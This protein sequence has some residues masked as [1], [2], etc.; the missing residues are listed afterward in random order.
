MIAN[1]LVH[2]SQTESRHVYLNLKQVAI[3]MQKSVNISCCD[4]KKESREGYVSGAHALFD[5]APNSNIKR[6]LL[7]FDPEFHAIWSVKISARRS[8]PSK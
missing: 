4:F 5:I 7:S 8:G 3:T 1:L 2:S 6:K